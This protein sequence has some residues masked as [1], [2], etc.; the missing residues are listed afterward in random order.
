V[1]LA[2]FLAAVSLAFGQ[3]SSISGKIVDTRGAAVASVQVTL[4]LDG[5]GPDRQAE[6]DEN[7]DF[8]FPGVAAGSWRL[9]FAKKGFAEKTS[10]G[11]IGAGET[12]NLP[13][14]SL[15]IDTVTTEVN[16]TET[17]AQIAQD[18]IKEEEEQRLF[19]VLPNFYTSYALDAAPLNAKQK[20]ELATKSWLDPTAFVINAMVAGV[21]QARNSRKGFG[22]GAEGYA[23][24]YG[25]GLAEHGTV[26]LLGK[27][28]APVVFKQDP[29]YFY[30][31]T[32]TTRSRALYA[33]SRTFMCRGD[34]KKD[35][36]CYS[37][38]IDRFGEGFLTNYY[39][40]AADRDSSSLILQ[41]AALGIGFEAM[42]NLFRE[43]VA[44]K[45]TKKKP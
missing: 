34:N 39:Y 27:F 35:Q 29:R 4:S 15:A 40:P 25:A 6:S 20:L 21:G 37:S 11:E 12:L 9:S 22:Q 24:R 23:K 1:L 13:P 38:L 36:F 44:K 42:G 43:F 10:S 33:I 30:K 31:G 28:V 32:G 16:V 45:I 19:G 3:Q 8:T 14:T 18:Q 2:A 17:Q 26:L 5:R 7:G 41:N